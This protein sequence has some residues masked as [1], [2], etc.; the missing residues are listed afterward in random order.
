MM[1]WGAN[2][3]ENPNGNSY[4]I[5][6][7][8][9]REEF[10]NKGTQDLLHML[11]QFEEKVKQDAQTYSR[12]WF[13][14]PTMSREVID[15]LWSP[16]LKYPKNQATMEP[17]TTRPPTLKLKLPSW[18][19]EFKF[20][21][22][23][24]QNNILIPNEDGV[25]PTELIPKGSEIAC[26]IQCGGIWFANGKFGVTWKLFQGVVKPTQSLAKGQCHIKLD[27]SAEVKKDETLVEP[28]YDSDGETNE[29]VSKVEGSSVSAT[30][31]SEP[32][33]EPAPVVEPEKPVKKVIKKKG[34]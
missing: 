7:Q 26:I 24:T 5:S 30:S 23:D 12:D 14:K 29:V 34:L 27:G 25:T 2:V 20:E 4:D 28:T 11:Q 6:L 19:G 8:F 15:A 9:P 33:V 31:E 13:G 3:Y 1:T 10:S 17:D 21:L 22:F 18:G 16:M 32:D